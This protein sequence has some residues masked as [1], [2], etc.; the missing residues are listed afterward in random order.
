MSFLGLGGGNKSKNDNTSSGWYDN[1]GNTKT[2]GSQMGSYTNAT[3]VGFAAIPETEDYRAFRDW[4]PQADASI[5]PTFDS[6][7]QRGQASY[8]NIG[9]GYSSP[10]LLGAQL[11][12]F[13]ESLNT[14][15]ATAKAADAARVNDQRM[16][17]LG[18]LYAG[19]RPQFYTKGTSGTT[20]MDTSGYTDS[21]SSGRNFQTGQ[22]T[23][24]TPG[25]SIFSQL[26]QG[27]GAVLPFI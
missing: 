6:E 24:T 10:Q 23:Q 12:G 20:S 8:N 15:R 14:R 26:L 17:Q 9:G 13:D 4:R 19:Q 1:Q 25:Q 2:T 5:D 7:R 21:A 27:A 22:G 11:R 3:D 18:T 16:S